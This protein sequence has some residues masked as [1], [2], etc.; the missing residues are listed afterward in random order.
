LIQYL[1]A[2]KGPDVFSRGERIED[3]AFFFLHELE[4]VIREWIALVYHRTRQ[5]GLAISEWPHLGLSPK[6]MFEAGVA[7]AGM[8]RILA[9]PE[10]VYDFLQVHPRTIQ[11]Y[12]VEVGGLRYNGAVLAAYRNTE[13]PYGGRHAGKWPIRVNPDDVRYV[14][15]HDPADG[16]WHALEWEHAPGLGTPFSAEAA[17]YARRLALRQDRWP[18]EQAALAEVLGQW[19]AG[20]VTDRR[21]RH[22]AVRLGTERAALPAPQN[23]A[24][25]AQQV[26]A[27][28]ALATFI[29]PSASSD[30]HAHADAGQHADGGTD[31]DLG[32]DDDDSEEIFDTPSGEDG[33]DF[34]ADAFEVIE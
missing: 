18:D 34:Y 4:D 9:T 16:T 29:P 15:F 3:Q 30:L 8:L 20:L 27:L 2:Y 14:Y 11:H 32:G 23:G 17:R 13:S 24:D 28:P 19:E 22:M 5:D 12:G 7:K 6:E 33:D 1:P 10:L 21:E 26:A 31:V 25:P